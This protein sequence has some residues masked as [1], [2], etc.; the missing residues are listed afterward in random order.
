[1]PSR[2]KRT[3]LRAA[4]KIDRLPSLSAD[5]QKTLETAIGYRFKDSEHLIHALIHPSLID[6]YRGGAGFS[7]QRMEFLGDRVLG[8]VIAEV[9]INKYP[10]ER[11]G[12][13]TKH[14]HNLV[15][16]PTCAE[17]G[18]SFN[19]R[20][21][22]FM[23]ASM[24]VSKTGA[25]DKAV[26]D[27]VEAL[28]AAIYIDGGLDA[29]ERFIKKCWSFD[30]LTKDTEDPNANPKTRLSDWCGANRTAYA[31]YET[32]ETSG[33]DHNP[34]FTVKASV[35]DRGEAIAKGGNKA[36]AERAAASALLDLLDK[37]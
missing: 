28:I 27:A 12:F 32:L 15:S 4:S 20:D 16:G 5:K 11:E 8:L 26:A 30:R 9:L 2:P 1:R 13:M 22:I 17:V 36:E 19:L 25:Y 24:K 37:S 29:A 35:E 3:R 33:P 31:V 23:D 6:E 7:N 18:A 14:F 34:I 10:K 21:Y